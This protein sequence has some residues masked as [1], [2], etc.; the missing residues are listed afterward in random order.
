MT[1]YSPIHLFTYLPIQ[2]ISMSAL[3]LKMCFKT[4]FTIGNGV[5]NLGFKVGGVIYV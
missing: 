5:C 3:N 1:S 2:K 4:A